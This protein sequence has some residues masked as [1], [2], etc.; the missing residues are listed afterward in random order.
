MNEMIK[1]LLIALYLSLI[2]TANA[3]PKAYNNFT[4]EK[5][6][7]VYDGDTIR[8]DIA[9]CDPAQKMAELKKVA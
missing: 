9:N 7:S 6:I 4:V 5:L 3:A 2:S 1:P 8:V